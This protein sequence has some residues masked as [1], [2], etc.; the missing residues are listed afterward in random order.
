MPSSGTTGSLL[1][2]KLHRPPVPR[3]Y[4]RRPRLDVD[5]LTTHPVTLVSA[6]A[7]FGKSVL[8]S[9]WLEAWT[10]RSAWVSLDESDNDL[11][12][13]VSYVCAAVETVFPSALPEVCDRL[14]APTLPPVMLLA[15]TLVNELDAIEEPFVLVLDDV[16]RISERAVLDLLTELMEHRPRHLHL[17]LIGRRDPFLPIARLRARDQL[18]DVRSEDLGF[19]VEETEAFLEKV[20]GTEVS[21]E[22]AGT[23]RERTEGWATGL[24][25]AALALRGEVDVEHPF[26]QR[27]P[28]RDV[29]SYLLGEVLERQSPAVRH[30]LLYSSI[31]DRFC[32][33]LCDALHADEGCPAAGVLDG[34]G[35]VEW[36]EEAGLFVI[37]LDPENGWFRYHHLFRDL[38]LEEA[39]RRLGA[40]AIAAVH[41]RASEWFEAEGLITDSI[42]QALEGRDEDWAAD[43]VERSRRLPHNSDDWHLLEKWLSFIPDTV[44]QDRAELLLARAWAFYFRFSFDQ[45]PPI[46]DRAEALLVDAADLGSE[47]GEI[48]FFRGL[49]A[50]FT[51]EGAASLR[52]LEAALDL[53][54]VSHSMY[55]GEAEMIFGLAV[56]MVQGSGQARRAIEDL[57]DTCPR[58]DYLRRTRQV[59]ALIYVDLIA[60]NLADAEIHNRVLV[61]DSAIGGSAHALAWG[62]YLQGLIHLHRHELNE[63]VR[64]LKRAVSQRFVLEA[65]AAADCM[66]GLVYV[67]Q[68]LGHLDEARSTLGLLHD[69]AYRHADPEYVGIAKSCEV[70]LSIMQNGVETASGW[71][72][73]GIDPPNEVMVFWLEVP[74]VTWC[75]ALIAEGS[76]GSLGEAEEKLTRLADQCEAH[77]NTYQ[78]IPILALKSLALD[79]QGRAAEALRVLE[80]AVALARPGGFIFP[81][82]EPGA[83]MR[84]LLGRLRLKSEEQVF[85]RRVLAAFER[86][87]AAVPAE[88]SPD[89]RQPAGDSRIGKTGADLTT[90]EMDVLELLGERLQDKEIATRLYVTKHTVNHHLKRIYRKLGVGGRRQAVQRATELGILNRDNPR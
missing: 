77:H 12:Q 72:Q 86:V 64:P 44:V 67:Q 88:T 32:I 21:V 63:A 69:L 51:G 34:A 25:L 1:R 45:I 65:R 36:V 28:V 71:L 8:V 68:A 74:S 70:R 75:R 35:F 26:T 41:G 76:A 59:G 3:D 31:V 49:F 2:T 66:A 54:P 57:L 10:G 29:M 9:G 33:P 15:H 79:Q 42:E 13:F 19:T 84:R 43:I 47:I 87:A 61:S 60:G 14:E 20:L 48:A 24:R 85:V 55:R 5:L 82:V 17:V 46:L 38:L 52:H 78:L 73:K 22:V 27:K 58:T 4:V 90:R 37:P 18:T 53:I 83:D 89:D 40:E 6:A 50:F 62:G 16:H 56:Q 23:W 7:G 30:H 80:E 39:R 81:F 11:R